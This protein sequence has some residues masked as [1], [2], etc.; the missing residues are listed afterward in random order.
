MVKALEGVRVLDL[1]RMY[2]GPMCTMLLAE[3]GAEVIKVEIPQGGDGVRNLAPQTQGLEGYPFVIL[4]RGKQG[5]TLNLSSEAG[6]N[7][8]KELAG[9]CDILVENFTPGVIELSLIHI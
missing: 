4:N 6:R 5:I 8:C 3:L 7:I 9:K 1:S 2:G